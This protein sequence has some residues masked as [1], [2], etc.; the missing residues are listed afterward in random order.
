MALTKIVG[1]TKVLVAQGVANL[2]KNQKLAGLLKQQIAQQTARTNAIPIQ[3]KDIDDLTRKTAAKANEVE[4]L[5]EALKQE[6]NRMRSMIPKQKAVK[7]AIM[8]KKRAIKHAKKVALK[9][10]AKKDPVAAAC[11]ATH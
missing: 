6:N 11:S 8:K 1:Q 4:L 7:H 9:K 3:Q 2:K 5:A 10:L